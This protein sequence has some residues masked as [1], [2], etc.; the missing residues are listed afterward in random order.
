MTRIY[1]PEEFGLFAVFLA[2]FS[3]LSALVTGRYEMAIMLPEDEKDSLSL[4]HLSLIFSFTFSAFIAV[5]IFLFSAEISDFF[6]NQELNFWLYFLPFSIFFA[7]IFQTFNYWLNRNKDYKNIAM[8]KIVLGAGTSIFQLLM[9]MISKISGGLIVGYLIGQIIVT[10]YFLIKI[11][12]KNLSKFSQI[13][14]KRVISNAFEYKKFPLIS[15][16]TSILDKSAVQMPILL[17]SK[18]FDQTSTG[19]F[20]A[21]TRFLDAPF[22]LLNSSI[23]LVLHQ[24]VVVVSRESPEDLYKLILIMYLSLLGFT[25]PLIILVF[26]FGSEIFNILLGSSWGDVGEISFFLMVVVGYRFCVSPLSSVL[27]LKDTLHLGAL[28]QIIYFFTISITL[29]L[30]RDLSFKD[31]IFI[32]MVHEVTLYTLYLCF[33]LYGCRHKNR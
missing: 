26:F 16:F 32:F 10:Y 24:R 28:W 2:L 6:N 13:N 29:F 25:L 33:I 4:F 21:L 18:F 1:S 27:N 8:G 7:G 19:T 17:L 9:R 14:K 15:S 3:I 11:F 23:A 5:I 31:F 30:V 20:S 22:A 12:K